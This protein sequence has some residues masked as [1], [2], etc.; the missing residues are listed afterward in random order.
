MDCDKEHGFDNANHRDG[1][2]ADLCANG[3][4]IKQLIILMRSIPSLQYRLTPENFQDYQS[5]DLDFWV[6]HGE[7]KLVPRSEYGDLLGRCSQRICCSKCG[8]GWHQRCALL[9]GHE[10]DH[11]AASP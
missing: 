4:K 3:P 5:L 1:E 2:M 6:E 7:H 9:P 11:S 10:G 8:C